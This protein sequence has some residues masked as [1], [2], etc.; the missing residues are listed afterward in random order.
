[1]QPFFW[2]NSLIFLG[3]LLSIPYFFVGDN[4]NQKKFL[5]I[6]LILLL[7][8]IVEI[9][10]KYKQLLGENNTFIYNI[11]YVLIGLSLKI[12]FFYLVF[13]E[14]KVKRLV[15]FL[16]TSFIIWCVI[17]S[18][19]YQTFDVFHH[20][21]LAFGSL[22][23]IALCFF[24]FYGI[25][26]KN[27]YLEMNLLAVPEFWIISFLMFFY[28]ASLLY[29]ISFSFLTERME[30]ELLLKLNFLIQIIGA[31]MYMV[32]GLAFYAPRLF[33]ETAY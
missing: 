24:Y 30:I 29:F 5:I 10:G 33:K 9:F 31:T 27:W 22:M 13:Q 16:M 11:G 20:Y 8:T 1:M 17:N 28:S 32:M 7:I 21:S 19:F 23:I 26:F 12:F 25:F 18:L 14:K 6:F 2:Y 3:M 4:R 15:L